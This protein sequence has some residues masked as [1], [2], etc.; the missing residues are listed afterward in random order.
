MIS[1][2]SGESVLHEE[3]F[4]LNGPIP[5]IWTRNYFSHVPRKTSLGE[6]WHINYDQSIR[7]DRAADSFFWENANGNIIELPYLKIEDTAVITEEKIQY[8]HLEDKVL[9]QDYDEKLFYHYEYVGGSQDTYRLTKITR[10]RF[11]IQLSYNASGRLEK[12]ID[13]S[14]RTLKIERDQEQRISSVTQ[15]SKTENDKRLISYEYNEEGYL[16][17]VRD[18]LKQEEQFAYTNGLLRQRT[19]RN[20]A[21]QHWEFENTE[22]NAKCTKRWFTKRGQQ[23]E[24][25]AYKLGHTI[26][27]D[28]EGGKTTHWHKN[29]EIIQVTDPL[30][31]SEI[32]EYNLNGLVMRYTDKLGL[33]T[34]YGYDDYG[35]KTSE[36][37]PNGGSTNYIFEDNNLVMAKNAKNAVWIWQYDDNSF[38]SVRIGPS[39]DI[40]RY[41][42]KD[43]LLSKI[44]DANGLE[45]HLVYNE[46]NTLEK[47]KLPNGEETN[48]KYNGQGQLLHAVSNQDTSVNYHYDELGRVKQV[49]TIDGNMVR[50][51]YDGVGNVIKA[52]DKYHHVKFAYSATGQLESREENDVQIKFAYSKSDQLKAITNEHKSIYRFDRDKNGQIIQESGFDGLKRQYLRNTGGQVKNTTTPDGRKVEYSYDMLGNV[53]TVTYDDQ[54]KEIFTYD[55]SGELIEA[56]NENGRVKLVRDEVGK[57]LEEFQNDIRIKNSY[58]RVGERVGLIS[59]LG[60][61]IKISRNKLGQILNTEAS[62]GESKWEVDITRN[63]LGLEI[64]RSLPGNV[65]SSWQRDKSG[66]PIQHS[67]TANEQQHTKKQYRWDVND[68]LRSIQDQLKNETINFEHDLFG[69]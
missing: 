5:L 34:Y 26:V 39:K 9:I 45:T 17:I 40:T 50:L 38:L 37:L 16:S 18:A 30:G 31:N 15:V 65:T 44:I 47:V 22:E 29:G 48:W 61:D 66:R 41:E 2:I 3:D 64:E 28:A 21:T 56:I 67:V 13:S 42:Y 54:T 6:T 57:V 53:S 51:E 8:T 10:H 4:Q 14:N 68:R 7:I 20:G 23:L 27:T 35:N 43:D 55:K 62:Q 24:Y 69:N 1:L 19:D 32:W 12:I 46:E 52:K 59:N 58:D 33:H 49:K 11:Q 25:F 36:R 63:L 60:A